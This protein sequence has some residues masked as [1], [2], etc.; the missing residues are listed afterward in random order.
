MKTYQILKMTWRG[1]EY[2]IVCHDEDGENPF[3]L[4]KTETVRNQYGYPAP[5]TKRIA[6]YADM[7]SCMALL[8]MLD[9]K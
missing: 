4:Y 7:N 9:W 8:A 3:W 1:V 2:K 5:S 6:K